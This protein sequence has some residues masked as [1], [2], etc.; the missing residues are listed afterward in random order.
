MPGFVWQPIGKNNHLA[1]IGKQKMA[2]Q[3]LRELGSPRGRGWLPHPPLG[4]ETTFQT[5]LRS[6]R[7]RMNFSTSSVRCRKAFSTIAGF[8]V[9]TSVSIVPRS[10]GMDQRLGMRFRQRQISE[11]VW[12]QRLPARRE[13]RLKRPSSFFLIAETGSGIPWRLLPSESTD[14]LFPTVTWNP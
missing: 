10:L 2:S 9:I 5:R 7:L 4:A 13:G 14:S 12:L 11:G 3:T 8:A 1:W 6:V